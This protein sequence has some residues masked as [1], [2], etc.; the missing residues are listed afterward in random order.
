MEPDI[1][2]V[3][4]HTSTG[5]SVSSSSSGRDSPVAMERIRTNHSQRSQRSMATS[6]HRLD[7]TDPWENLEHALAPDPNFDPDFDMD[8][9]P[10]DDEADDD[11][12][13]RLARYESITRT[14]TAAS[15]ATSIASRPPDFEVIFEDGDP[16]NP[17]NW[18]LWY[19]VW[20]LVVLAATGLIT[21]LYS[22][23]YASS[24]PGLMEEFGTSQT[25]T[26][27][28]MTTY[29]LGLAAGSIVWA[30]MSELYGRRPV[31]LSCLVVWAILVV[32]SGV[33]KNFVT[34]LVSRFF[35]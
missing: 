2:K 21:V 27:L 15:A 13:D 4:A 26:T 30:P 29:L 7:G 35:W 16:E 23:S 5:T 12:P 17:R 14:R 24:A 3:D 1:E 11:D 32:P 18:P 25:L 6:R 10:D 33:A 8:D 31:Y 19:R 20:I 34:I 28:G 9:D 22:T